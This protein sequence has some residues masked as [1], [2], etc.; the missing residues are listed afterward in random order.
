M[1]EIQLIIFE[2]IAKLLENSDYSGPY[3]S[4]SIQQLLGRIRAK[5]KIGTGLKMKNIIIKFSTEYLTIEHWTEG[6][7]YEASKLEY[8]DPQLFDK[9][10]T[11]L[12]R[13]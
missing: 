9:I 4:H 11:M 2:Q 5:K 1:N 12:E 10:Q 7:D 8:T 13:R 6:S 3:G